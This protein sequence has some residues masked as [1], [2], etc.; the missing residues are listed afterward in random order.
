MMMQTWRSDPDTGLTGQGKEALKLEKWY[1]IG[2]DFGSPFKE[3]FETIE[4]QYGITGLGIGLQSPG[5]AR[6]S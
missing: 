4:H 6:V 1:K 5:R 2:R 3:I